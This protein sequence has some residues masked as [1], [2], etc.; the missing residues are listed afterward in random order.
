MSALVGG[1]PKLVVLILCNG[2]GGQILTDMIGEIK[3]ASKNIGTHKRREL[4]WEAYSKLGNLALGLQE[5]KLF[6]FI[7]FHLKVDDEDASN[8]KVEFIPCTKRQ[9]G[10]LGTTDIMGK[11]FRPEDS[12]NKNEWFSC[13]FDDD[14]QIVY[15]DITS[16]EPVVYLSQDQDGVFVGTKMKRRKCRNAPSSALKTVADF[17]TFKATL[18]PENPLQSISWTG[19]DPVKIN[20][21]NFLLCGAFAKPIVEDSTISHIRTTS[22]DEIYEF[23]LSKRNVFLIA[24]ADKLIQKMLTDIAKNEAN[25]I[26]NVSV[27][28]AGVARQ[29]GLIKTVFVDSAKKKF[30]DAVKAEGDGIEMFVIKDAPE[31]SQFMQYGGVVFEL[32]YRADLEIFM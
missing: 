18:L 2:L 31:S 9:R 23:F 22:T 21:Y 28:L 15:D 27:K 16:G 1:P 29:N 19:N 3:T 5:E 17:E 25:P 30:I 13:Y 6:G 32:H 10:L 20:A 7:T 26:C 4:Y 14:A 12:E 11:K 24:E 8:G